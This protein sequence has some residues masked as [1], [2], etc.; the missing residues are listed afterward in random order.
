MKEI[1][2]IKVTSL[3]I[4]EHPKNLIGREVQKDGKE[5]ED[6]EKVKFLFLFLLPLSLLSFPHFQSPFS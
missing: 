2:V 1:M 5:K 4:P 3:N 6:G